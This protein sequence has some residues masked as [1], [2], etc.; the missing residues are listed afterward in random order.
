MRA[1][2]KIIAA[3]LALGCTVAPVPLAL[4]QQDGAE[5]AGFLEN[6]IQN[7]L[8]GEGREVRVVGLSGVLSSE[9]SIERIE[10]A[11]DDGTWLRVQDVT[12]D[13]RR[14]ALLRGRLEVDALTVGVIDVLRKPLPGPEAPPKLAAD[15]DAVPEP[16][17]LPDLPVAVNVAQLSMGAI[18]LGAPVLGE[19]AALSL[20]GAAQLEGGEG[21]AN[22]SLVR[23]DGQEAAYRVAAGYTNADG[24]LLI[25]LDLSE[26]P[27]GL[28]T[29]L[30]GIPGSPSLELTLKGED[31][32]SDFTATLG[33]RTSDIDRLSGTIGLRDLPGADTPEREITADV[34]GDVADLF[35]P[36]YRDFFGRRIALTLRA[37][38]GDAIGLDV[39]QLEL[40]TRGLQLTG[41]ANLS[42]AY[43]P[44]ELDL[45][46]HLGTDLGLPVVLPMPGPPVLVHEADLDITYDETAGDTF[47]VRMDG[48]GVMRADGLLL[49]TLSFATEGQLTKA[50]PTDITAALADIRA[51]LGG[52]SITDPAL[53]EA[54]GDNLDLS[55]RVD[56]QKA[57]PLSV[58][59]FRVASGDLDLRGDATVTGLDTQAIALSA[60][61]EAQAGDLSRFSAISGQDLGG[62]IDAAVDA[63]FDTVSGAFDVTLDGVS[64]DLVI[65]DAGADAL[66]SGRVELGLDAARTA[67]GISVDR[68]R[69]N[70][71]RV[72]L[73]GNGGID[74]QGW[75]RA[76]RLQGRVG[77]PDGPAV[78]LPA[79]GP[80]MTLQSAQLNLTY[81]PE[82]GDAFQLD[83]LAQDFRR[84]G[85]LAMDEAEVIALGELRRSGS[86]VEGATARV[87]AALSGL[88]ATDPNLSDAIA[89]GASFDTDIAWDAAER[90]LTVDGLDL[91]SGA[92]ALSGDLAVSELATDDM[93]LDARVNAQ[94]GPLSR[95]APLT[96]LQLGG[97][98]TARGTLSYAVG[99]G[100]FD[101]DMRAEGQD[102]ATGIAE[103]DQLIGGTSTIVARATRDEAGLDIRQAEIRTRELTATAT[104]GIVDEVTTVN[105][106]AALRDVGLFAP[107]FN[108]P[109]TVTATARNRND[110][111]SLNG[112]L[113]G[114]GGSEARFAGDVL[115][116]DGTMGLDVRGALPL[117]LANRFLLPRTIDGTARFDI[118]VDGTPGL[119]AVSGSVTVDGARLAAPSL[120]LALEDIGLRV[121]L[122]DARAQIDL[123]AALSSGGRISV[124][125]PVGL[126]GA[127]P[128]D[129][130]ARLENLVLIDPALYEI[131][132]NGQIGVNGPLTGGANIAGRIDIGRSEI[133]IPDAFGGGGAIPD[134]VHVNEPAASRATRRRAGLIS[135]EPAGGGGGGGGPVFG[136]DIVISA[137][138]EIFVRGRGLDVELGGRIDIG[139]TT[140]APAPQGGLQLIR[141][142]LDLLS[143]RLEFDEAEISLQGDLD[144]DIRMVASSDSGD[145]RSQIVIEGPVSAPEFRFASQPELPE[146]EV[147]A[148][149]FFGKPVRDLT[150]IE[151]A[152]LASA[153][154]RLQGGGG[155]VFGFARETLGVDD[156]SVATDDEGNTAV[157][158]GRYISERVYTDVTVGSDGTSEVQLNYEIRQG[159][160]ARGSFTNDGET[161]VGLVFERDY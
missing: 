75:P 35:L 77:A 94:T 88:S 104:G 5:D 71:G 48:T 32:L 83:V 101:V 92:L 79:P 132:L 65:G 95:F 153:I 28:I 108:G 146:D 120:R 97:T 148:Q 87:T 109:L 80:R 135:D 125:G 98:A 85:E 43:L 1:R 111:W 144:P 40:V 68:L 90:S 156:L 20:S 137:P 62:A 22:L 54:A 147:L 8:G 49:D 110:T 24:V 91:T 157:T 134:M 42:P 14:L 106:D 119:D 129:I 6:L 58:T 16:F 13:W 96:G 113:T 141:G 25:D 53:W 4:A 159:L 93:A 84:E 60:Q 44:Q 140:A 131:G 155:G 57:G 7:A 38:Q 47:A 86:D 70:G 11:D 107:G 116:P 27:E 21:S 121:A 76:V 41:S 39:E 150:P 133:K 143:Q 89:P 136:L 59:G 45:Q 30:A 19:A 158:A 126:T 151:L 78:V 72:D 99:T 128:A 100:F 138:R 10:I 2:T 46:A 160:S 51:Q 12:L 124:S 127:I 102:L 31:P 26:A 74:A 36:D 52:F 118:A 69:L 81:D 115:R 123:G 103:A 112:D 130:T 23:I 64:R 114:P 17:S 37:R 149:M 161:G 3:V 73:T 34:A 50:G 55:G 18:R 9:A 122:A 15:P 63:D 66:L 33:L 61:V 142:R 117:G 56:W 105:L 139:G 67:D 29:T 82:T 145:V 152:Q 154:N